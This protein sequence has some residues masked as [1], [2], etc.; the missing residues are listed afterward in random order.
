[1]PVPYA[2]D[3]G[4]IILNC[5]EPIKGFIYELLPFFRTEADIIKPMVFARIG[6]HAEGRL[7]RPALCDQ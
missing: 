3:Y 5:D 1:M 4:T 6:Y 7:V 2:F